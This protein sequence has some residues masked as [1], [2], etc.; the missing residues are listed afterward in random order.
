MI[1]Q[2]TGKP[3]WEAKTEV[4]GMIGKFKAAL[5]AYEERCGTQHQELKDNTNLYTRHKPH[6]VLAIFGPFNFPAH[7][8]HGHIIPALLA[9]NTIV[10]KPS[11]LVPGVGE[12]ITAIWSEADLPKGVIN[13]VQGH[14]D[15]GVVLNENAQV[16]GILFTGSSNVGLQLQNSISR[17]PHRMIALEMGGNNPLIFNDSDDISASAYCIVQSAFIT[18]GQRCTCARRLVVVESEYSERLIEELITLTKRIIIGDPFSEPQPFIGPLIS[19][20]ATE[21]VISHYQNLKEIGARVLVPIKRLEDN[22]PFI[23]PGIVDVTPINNLEDIEVFGPLL[24]VIRVKSID[25]AI[26]VA[27]NTR[28]G[29][30]AGIITQDS[31]IHKTFF[32]RIRSGIVNWNKPLTGASGMAPFGGVGISGNHRPSGYYASDYCSYPVASIETESVL[33]LERLGPGFRTSI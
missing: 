5:L 31:G 24:K 6:G 17:Y 30:S 3:H 14:S 32:E 1:S 25:A 12:L 33:S 13:L 15:V 23:T 7:L 20:E 22:K 21:K 28:Y 29:L 10:F 26:T 2:E 27:N 9:G 16:D 8:P 18:A 11:E 19:M 4:I